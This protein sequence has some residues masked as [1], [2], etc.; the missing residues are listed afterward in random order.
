MSLEENKRLIRRY[1]EEVVNTGNV[2]EIERFISPDYC[3]IHEGKKHHVGIAGAKEHVLGVR[4]TYP[5]LILTMDRQIAE[6]DWVATCIT[7]RGT[8]KGSWLGMKPT[9]RPVCYTGVNIEKVENG[10]I[11]EH[12]GAANLLLQRLEIGAVTV[13]GEE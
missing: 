9:G 5:D 12:G 13:V 2:D 7:A 10:R 6:G 3:E 8:H 4:R 11:S 1:I